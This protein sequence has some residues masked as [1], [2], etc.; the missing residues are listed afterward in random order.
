MGS[1]G[2]ME[3]PRRK[4]NGTSVSWTRSLRPCF[5]RTQMRWAVAKIEENKLVGATP[6]LAVVDSGAVGDYELEVSAVGSNCLFCGKPGHRLRGC[7]AVW[8]A[9]SKKQVVFVPNPTPSNPGGA[10]LVLPDGSEFGNITP[11][12]KQ[13][14][15]S[16]DTAVGAV[17]V[18][19]YSRF[20]DK[21]HWSDG[22]N[23]SFD[24]VYMGA[25]G[26]KF[27]AA[28][29]ALPPVHGVGKSDCVVHVE[30][31]D[32]TRDAPPARFTPYPLPVSREQRQVPMP[33]GDPMD[34]DDDENELIL[35]GRM[36]RPDGGS[37][38]VP[39]TSKEQPNVVEQSK[40]AD[41]AQPPAGHTTIGGYPCELPLL[42]RAHDPGN[43]PCLHD[44]CTSHLVGVKVPALYHHWTRKRIPEPIVACCSETLAM[45]NERKAAEKAAKQ[46]E[47]GKKGKGKKSKGTDAASKASGSDPANAPPPPARVQVP[48]LPPSTTLLDPIE[49]SEP[50]PRRRASMPKLG[51]PPP[52]Q[53]PSSPAPFAVE[54]S[55]HLAPPA[56]LSPRALPT[57]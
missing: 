17:E 30:G 18:T 35:A 36:P 15:K 12:V 8:T 21:T 7:P 31:V 2:F 28:V 40:A 48:S 44:N 29:E 41:A 46:A 45:F 16:P 33:P 19:D 43:I 34:L 32:W 27:V 4:R 5:N 10:K 14:P 57:D 50:T 42:Q 39:P 55:P 9:L 38:P 23:D 47:G 13:L 56:T 51:T 37:I 24:G 11:W 25:D 3:C 54:S 53:P 20:D 49:S 26:D 6:G 52:P 1:R 22:D